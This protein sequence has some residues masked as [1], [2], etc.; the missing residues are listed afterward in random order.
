MAAV[1]AAAVRVERAGPAVLPEARVVRFDQVAEMVGSPRTLPAEMSRRRDRVGWSPGRQ[2]GSGAATVPVAVEVRALRVA[3]DVPGVVPVVAGARAVLGAVRVE[4][5]ALDLVARGAQAEDPLV[6][7]EGLA[8]LPGVQ[9]EARVPVPVLTV[10]VP[11]GSRRDRGAVAH[12]VH[13]RVPAGLGRGMGDV[14]APLVPVPAMSGCACAGPVG[15]D[16]GVP[17]ARP[18]GFRVSPALLAVPNGVPGAERPDR[19]AIQK[20]GRSADGRI[21][22]YKNSHRYAAGWLARISNP[23]C[24]AIS[25]AVPAA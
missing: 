9:L 22:G 21:A 10:A 19:S 18:P 1:R 5:L 20:A 3:T 8:H 16:E 15:A 12:P 25:K 23:L 14:A 2:A 13:P 24:P 11:T 4:A 7:V 6:A 17:V